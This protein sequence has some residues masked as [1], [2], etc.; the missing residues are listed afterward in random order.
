MITLL[1]ALFALASSGI[2]TCDLER[3][4]G[5][6]SCTRAVVDRLPINQ[7]QTIGTHNSYKQAISPAEMAL[8]TASAAAMAR[9]IDYS[10]PP[11]DQQLEA[12]A[13]QLELDL[14]NDPQ[15]GRFADPLARRLVGA[16]S[17][18]YDSSVMRQPG[19]KVMHMQDVDYRSSCALFTDC[20]RTIRHWS[21]MHRD[22]APILILL[23][24][25]EGGLPFPGATS[26]LPFDAAAMDAID[27]E[28]RSVFRPREMIT[29]DQVQGRRATLRESVLAGGWPALGAARGRVFFAL[30]APMSQVSLYRGARRSLEGRV[31]FVNIDEASPA[32]GYITLNDPVGQADR[33]RAD[34]AAGY[35]VRTR[36]DADTAQSR[37]NDTTMREA[38]FSSGAQY[39]STDYMRPDTRFSIYT[40]AMPNGVRA[41]LSPSASTA[42]LGPP[43]G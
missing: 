32:A 11:L 6:G 42:H 21:R 10:H 12:G 39:I 2:E 16:A 25:K 36:A 27:R 13:R 20:L 38:A 33:I 37:T 8:I 28:I 9:T 1:A 30:D 24:L 31:M 3:P 43:H 19:M 4:S 40:V 34:V 5:R 26:A 23:N 22:H 35:I 41:R 17:P 29:P 18:P 15:G 7:I 14:L